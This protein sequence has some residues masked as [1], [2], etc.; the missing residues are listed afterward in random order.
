M[1]KNFKEIT[2]N[3]NENR[4]WIIRLAKQLNNQQM[5]KK[6]LSDKSGVASSTITNWFTNNGDP[7]LS[8]II[9]ITE[10]LNISPNYF[11]GKNDCTN[12][13]D[14]FIQMETGLSEEAIKKLRNLKNRAKNGAFQKK[15]LQ[16]I[17]LLIEHEN[18]Y[19][20]EDGARADFLA[21]LQ[22][23]LTDEFLV[24]G[25]E[26]GEGGRSIALVNINGREFNLDKDFV[27]RVRLADIQKDIMLFKK[28]VPEEKIEKLK[29]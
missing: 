27:E 1:N 10:A 16:I 24:S 12:P 9:G 7:T 13:K 18:G 3:P 21:H 17:S 23:Y 29:D 6:S 22:Q 28:R 19:E 25:E 15:K 4:E 8:S 26:V 14:N 5:S 11:F 20:I 2:L